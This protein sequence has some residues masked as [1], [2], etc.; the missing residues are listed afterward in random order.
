[1]Q[2][3]KLKTKSLV[4]GDIYL[5]HSAKNKKLSSTFGTLVKILTTT[6]VVISMEILGKAEKEIVSI[7]NIDSREDAWIYSPV[8]AELEMELRPDFD[9]NQWPSWTPRLEASSWVDRKFKFD[10]TRIHFLEAEGAGKGACLMR[11]EEADINP[12]T[13]R[14]YSTNFPLNWLQPTTPPDWR[15]PRAER[16]GLGVVELPLPP[17]PV[18]PEH[19]EAIKNL[20]PA[21]EDMV[22][23]HKKENTS[24]I[25]VGCD[26]K[27]I[28]RYYNQV[29]HRTIQN[30]C[31][32]KVDYV[33]TLGLNTTKIG[34]WVKGKPSDEALV[35]WVTYLASYSPYSEVFITKDP[36]FIIKYGYVIDADSP[37]R[38]VAG[39][40]YATRQVW[41]TPWRAEAFL[42]FY[43]AGLP[44]DVAFVFAS[45]CSTFNNGKMKL[46]MGHSGHNHFQ[47]S[48]ASDECFINFIKHTPKYPGQSYQKNVNASGGRGGVDGMWSE[49]YGGGSQISKS[50][51]DIRDNKAPPHA[52][53]LSVD[54]VVEKACDL[55]ED[56]M[57]KHGISL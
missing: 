43:K 11:M 30:E 45:Q 46:G 37:N 8:G 18:K 4:V 42:E 44:I 57:V 23:N 22:K 40:C 29:C 6:P 25:K 19:E 39:A 26:F 48:N 10:L 17:K 35:L 54:E 14:P 53:A 38:L 55:I 41:E 34:S 1:M 33:C 15:I 50:L 7:R 13:G 24:F 47:A 51:S 31:N 9:K 20:M 2:V 27:E 3:R 32:F 56:W 21:L 12:K 16:M 49:S 5:A 36:D 28:D 52:N